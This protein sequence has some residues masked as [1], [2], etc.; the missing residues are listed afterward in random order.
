[1]FNLWGFISWWRGMLELGVVG[2]S[3]KGLECETLFGHVRITERNEGRR[4]RVKGTARPFVH[5]SSSTAPRH[6]RLATDFAKD[7]LDGRREV[8]RPRL[9]SQHLRARCAN[10][11]GRRRACGRRGRSW[12]HSH[13]TGRQVNLDMLGRVRFDE[14]RWTKWVVAQVASKQGGCTREPRRAR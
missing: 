3:K 7:V 1:M 5:L 11:G 10:R 4:E 9:L 12:L 8:A 14:R 13:R 6:C 2:S